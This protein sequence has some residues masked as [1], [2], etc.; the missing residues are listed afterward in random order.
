MYQQSE[1][2]LRPPGDGERP[3]MRSRSE[4]DLSELLKKSRVKIEDPS[5]DGSS[6][7]RIVDTEK[8]NQT[9]QT[10]FD[11]NNDEIRI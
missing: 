7:F 3:L 4:Q 5:S 1:E 9:S 2:P 8:Q 11:K 6:S 10:N